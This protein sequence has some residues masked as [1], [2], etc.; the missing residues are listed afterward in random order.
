MI[1][2]GNLIVL[3]PPKPSSLCISEDDYLSDAIHDASLRPFFSIMSQVT[4]TEKV[5]GQTKRQDNADCVVIVERGFFPE[6]QLREDFKEKLEKHGVPPNH[7]LFGEDF[8]SGYFRMLIR[9]R[10]LCSE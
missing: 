8:P 9:I 6:K 3:L 1:T 4:S 7:I 10:E 2:N 5:F